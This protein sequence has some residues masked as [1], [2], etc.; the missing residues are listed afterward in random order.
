MLVW[1]GAA[2]WGR[3]PSPVQPSEARRAPFIW[4]DKLAIGGILVAPAQPLIYN[5]LVERE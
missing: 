3:A 2:V 5:Q 4:F 1:G